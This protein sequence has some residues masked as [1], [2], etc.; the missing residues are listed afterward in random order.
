MPVFGESRDSQA[1][2]TISG[3]M[4]PGP[5]NAMN[6]TNRPGRFV[7]SISHAMV[8]PRTKESATDP[9]TKTPVSR[10]VSSTAPLEK[11]DVKLL[12]VMTALASNG[13]E[14]T[15]PLKAVNICRLTGT[16]NR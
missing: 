8:N 2:P 5:I 12:M 13:S 6:H 7:R 9:P 1:C 4:T 15:G 3:G 16:T 14:V 10:A 11:I